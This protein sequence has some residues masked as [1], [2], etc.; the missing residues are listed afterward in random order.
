MPV[1]DA[2]QTADNRSTRKRKR[3]V[4]LLAVLLAL[5][6]IGQYFHLAERFEPAVLRGYIQALGIF[7]ILL[8]LVLFCLGLL[9]SVP[10][11]LFM[12]TAGLVWGIFP[13]AL[14]AL[15]GANLAIIFSFTL[16]RRL[17][18][19]GFESESIKNALVRKMLAGLEH[20]PLR[21]IAVLR[22]LFSTAPGLNYGF[23]LS[24]VSDRQHL[25]ATLLGTIVPVIGIV[26][27]SDWLAKVLFN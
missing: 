5:I 15:A 21:T 27:L 4:V 18:G 8:Y 2:V 7:G 3:L 9:F 6:A 17:N 20:R 10:G 26:F 11:I 24:A 23:A 14:I 13:G 25:V 12:V 1:N 16:V 19:A 22:L